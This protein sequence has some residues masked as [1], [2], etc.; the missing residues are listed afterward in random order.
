MRAAALIGGA[1]ILVGG[2]ADDE[3][4]LL[5]YESYNSTHN[6]SKSIRT[7]TQLVVC[8][9]TTQILLKSAT[10]SRTGTAVQGPVKV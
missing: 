4:V 9:S 2:Y 10:L 5:K 1:T 3:G 7:C 8:D 6:K